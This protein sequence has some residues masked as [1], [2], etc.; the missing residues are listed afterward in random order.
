MS[1]AA[2]ENQPLRVGVSHFLPPFSIEGANHQL[3]GFDIILMQHLC[4]ILQRQCKF[5]VMDTE[6]IVAAVADERVDLGISDLTISLERY[7][8]ADFTIPYMLSESRF[9][10]TSTFKSQSTDLRVL[11]N[12]QIGVQ[13][14]TVYADQLQQMGHLESNIVT[15]THESELIDA[16][17]QGNIDLALMSNPTALYWSNQTSNTL[18][19]IGE[20]I[21]YGFGIGIAV[22]PKKPELTQAINAAILRTQNSNEYT[23]IYQMYFGS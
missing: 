7:K 15:F 11:Q 14:N 19:V 13:A 16:L 9:L 3:S 8:Q 2:Q 20:P 17:N 4:G 21:L 22:N 18:R 23:Q 10:A 1:G 6:Q 5:V 12:K